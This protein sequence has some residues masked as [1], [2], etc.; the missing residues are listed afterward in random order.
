FQHF[1]QYVYVAPH[2]RYQFLAYLRSEEIPDGNGIQFD[3]FDPRHP[4]ELQVLTP[5]L[6]DNNDW[7][8]VQV[9]FESGA[10]TQM[11][12]I[13]LRCAPGPAFTN[14]LRGIVWVDDVSLV[15]VAHRR[16]SATR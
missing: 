10:D 15:P 3:I 13:L 8:P 12:E 6:T 2:Q 16:M 5:A 4:E 14:Q 9:D 1:F 11:L 7:T